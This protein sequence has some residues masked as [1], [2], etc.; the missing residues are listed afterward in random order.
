M[1]LALPPCQT[2]SVGLTNRWRNCYFYCLKDFAAKPLAFT[3]KDKPFASFFDDNLLEGFQVL[4]DVRP[5]EYMAGLV[6]PS[7]EFLSENQG[8][9]A[10][11]HVTANRAGG[12]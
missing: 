4:F 2:D 1:L 10:A 5:L 3:A 6:Q 11:K 9:E 12:R 7:L 8:E